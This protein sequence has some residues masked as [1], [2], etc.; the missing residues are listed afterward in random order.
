MVVDSSKY[1]L[2]DTEQA[3]NELNHRSSGSKVV[4]CPRFPVSCSPADVLVQLV[5][6]VDE[7]GVLRIVEADSAQ[8]GSHHKRADQRSLRGSACR[9]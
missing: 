5:L 9:F 1:E 3:N 8:N 6:Q 2:V 4:K 7:A